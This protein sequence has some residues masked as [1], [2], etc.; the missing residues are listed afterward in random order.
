MA[1]L[2]KCQLKRAEATRLQTAGPR[3]D[4]GLRG[5]AW[6]HPPA[7]LVPSGMQ[8]EGRHVGSPAMGL[9]R[10]SSSIGP[11]NGAW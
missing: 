5:P 8:S 2:N 11:P 3:K 7:L 4:P 10:N 6:R 1:N 9:Y